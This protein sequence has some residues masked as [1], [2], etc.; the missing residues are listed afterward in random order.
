ML[1]RAAESFVLAH[2][3]EHIVAGHLDPQ[4]WRARQRSNHE[5][6]PVNWDWADEFEADAL[7]GTLLIAHAQNQTERAFKYAGMEL[8]LIAIRL[9]EAGLELHQP[10][11]TVEGP[12][13]HPPVEMRQRALRGAVSAFLGEE[14]SLQPVL[15]AD[16]CGLGFEL[17]WA[18]SRGRLASQTLSDRWTSDR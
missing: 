13:P 7:A 2:E 10:P 1:V 17:L 15:I 9:V 14:L 6:V 18:E 8:S 12:S 3:Y 5:S 16:L 4:I 11:G